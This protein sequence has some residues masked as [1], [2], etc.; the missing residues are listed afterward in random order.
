MTI[1]KRKRNMGELEEL[2]YLKT[3]GDL[4]QHIGH[5]LHY[6]YTQSGKDVA[7]MKRLTR[8]FNNTAWLATGSSGWEHV[9][10]VL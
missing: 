9:S 1:K 2:T 6:S 3:V 4:R 5:V 10:K 8:V 7:Y